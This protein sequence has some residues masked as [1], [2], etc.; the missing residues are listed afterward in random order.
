MSAIISDCFQ[1]AIPK[2]S[3]D[4]IIFGNNLK[5]SE[6]MVGSDLTLQTKHTGIQ[7]KKGEPI[8]GR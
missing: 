3:F 7:W 6:I 8:K 5:T 4:A 1:I 2:R